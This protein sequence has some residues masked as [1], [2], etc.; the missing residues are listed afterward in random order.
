[1]DGDEL[2][3]HSSVIKLVRV[4]VLDGLLGEHTFVSR[5]SG[6][7]NTERKNVGFLR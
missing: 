7:K 5:T 1:M 6:F 3:Q 2:T 4:A